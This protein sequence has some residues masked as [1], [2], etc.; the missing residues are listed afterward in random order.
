MLGP[1]SLFVNIK[2]SSTTTINGRRSPV[3]ETTY[4]ISN[5]RQPYTLEIDGSEQVETFNIHIGEQFAEKL[6]QGYTNPSATLLDNVNETPAKQVD[7]YN[8]L[9]R[10]DEEFNGIIKKLHWLGGEEIFD[11][12]LFEETLATLLLYLLRG[13]THV[14]DA[15]A[16]LPAVKGSVKAELYKRVSI[17]ADYILAYYKENIQLDDIAA[18]ACLSKF[19]FLRLFKEV[20]KTSPHQYIQQL[21]MDSAYIYLAGGE[22]VSNIATLLGYENSNSFSRIFKQRTGVYPTQYRN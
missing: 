20:Y 11:K 7:F 19:H 6:L 16:G 3:D 9:Y 18:A 12:M 14:L 5:R 13:H 2:G 22:R 17:G 15:L 1:I 21:R 10:R 4:T 8:Q